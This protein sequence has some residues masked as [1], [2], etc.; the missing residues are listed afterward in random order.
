MRD[1]VIILGGRRYYD[2]VLCLLL[3]AAA[4]KG[5]RPSELMEQLGV[6]EPRIEELF[7]GSEQNLTFFSQLAAA[8][9]LMDRQTLGRLLR[10]RLGELLLTARKGS[11]LSA[12]TRAA[13]KLPPWAFGE[14]EPQEPAESTEP[15][16]DPE[17]SV[18]RASRPRSADAAKPEP[19]QV[20]PTCGEEQPGEDE[21]E[22][23]E[24]I[25]EAR[26][27]MAELQRT[28]EIDAELRRIG[29]IKPGQLEGLAEAASGAGAGRPPDT[30]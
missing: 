29:A 20:C 11:E 22:L 30:G 19:G 23:E 25:A 7:S 16:E 14:E 26:R 5:G 10:L 21:L 27:L 9:E 15:A 6:D 3:F 12:L 24:A 28:P 8:A 2:P 1:D 4:V 13:A 17:P 18:A